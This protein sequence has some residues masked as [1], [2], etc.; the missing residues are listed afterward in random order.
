MATPREHFGETDLSFGDEDFLNIDDFLL[1]EDLV[2]EDMK[3]RVEIAPTRTRSLKLTPEI[4]AGLEVG[5]SAVEE[6]YSTPTPSM[7]M[8]PALIFEERQAAHERAQKR[9]GQNSSYPESNSG[10]DSDS[11]SSELSD[12]EKAQIEYATQLSLGLAPTVTLDNFPRSI[13]SNITPVPLIPTRSNDRRR[14]EETPEIRHQALIAKGKRILELGEMAKSREVLKKPPTPY[15]LPPSAK[16][17]LEA[18]LALSKQTDSPKRNEAPK[19]NVEG[20]SNMGAMTFQYDADRN[21]SLG[22]HQFQ[23]L[24]HMALGSEVVSRETPNIS[25]GSSVN[26]EARANSNST[27]S[28]YMDKVDSKRVTKAEEMVKYILSK[29]SQ[30]PKTKVEEEVNKFLAEDS[31]LDDDDPLF[32]I[33]SKA[34]GVYKKAHKA[35]KR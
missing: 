24:P 35:G 17:A 12:E 7:G 21:K 29:D 25:L 34:E 23:T 16:M 31:T 10:H 2:S 3:S 5:L 18:G 33:I 27:Q 14:E 1:A 26:L 22:T 20:T 4:S 28:T 8:D 6:A 32:E 15:L 19:R 30:W 13:P 11:E 9:K